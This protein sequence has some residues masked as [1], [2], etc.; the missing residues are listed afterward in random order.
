MH[1]EESDMSDE[2]RME[3]DTQHVSAELQKNWGW[4]LFVGIAF[5]VLGCIVLLLLSTLTLNHIIYIGTIVVVAGLLMTISGI[6]AH[7]GKDKRWQILIGILY[8]AAGIVLILYPA[9]GVAGYSLVIAGFLLLTGIRRV[10]FGLQTRQ[11]VDG[12]S[13]TVFGGAASIALAVIIYSGWPVSGQWVVAL[14]I[15]IELILQGS[16]MVS[17]AIAARREQNLR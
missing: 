11:F 1:N 6:K 16:S 7:G 15:A 13:I 9:E 17:V 8:L 4:L 3:V 12:W 10:V 14:F 5:I 2:E